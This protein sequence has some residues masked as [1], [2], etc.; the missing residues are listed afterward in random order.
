M[1]SF[2]STFVLLVVLAVA[3]LVAMATF[4]ALAAVSLSPPSSDVAS[5]MW[6]LLIVFCVSALIGFAKRTPTMR[7]DAPKDDRLAAS[8]PNLLGHVST[9]LLVLGAA[10]L[11][12]ITLLVVGGA[13]SAHPIV[14]PNPES[15]F[16]RIGLS[17]SYAVPLLVIALAVVG[18]A[19]RERSERIAL[20]AGLLLSFCATAAYLLRPSD[21]GQLDALRWIRVAQLNAI[22][23]AYSP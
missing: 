18:H 22:V 6:M 16:A 1:A 19:V 21:A 12:V 8:T 5:A 23:S 15:V 3:P 2:S 9:L 20:A 11:V 17:A 7:A 10:P 14:G 13:L 4:V